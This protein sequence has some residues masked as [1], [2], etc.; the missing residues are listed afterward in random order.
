M[1]QVKKENKLNN[2]LK[3]LYEK[4]SFAYFLAGRLLG[5]RVDLLFRCLSRL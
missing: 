1:L 4:M 5:M 2:K 3:I